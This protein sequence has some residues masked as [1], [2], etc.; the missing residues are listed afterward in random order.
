MAAL[1][2]AVGQDRELERR[3]YSH[4]AIC[5]ECTQLIGSLRAADRDAAGLLAALDVP[6][7]GRS[8]AS[9]IRAAQRE[10][11]RP[12]FGGRRAAA[13]GGFLVVAAAAAAALP[14][15]PIHRFL[16]ARVGSGSRFDAHVKS[17]PKQ[18]VVEALSPAVS[19][20]TTPNSSLEVAFSGSGV[21][22]SLYVRVIDGGE[23]S[24]SSAS[25]GATYR[26]GPNRIAVVQSAP[27][28][29]HLDVPRSLRE[30][31][32][33]VGSAIVFDRRPS[34]GAASDSFTIQLARPNASR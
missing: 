13:I 16:V 25:S 9:V 8:V 29:F 1:I 18:A 32:V 22:G 10:K 21:G 20:E 14:S 7:S 3:A 4:L 31:R 2:Y 19:F 26:V 34:T 23:V 6:A 17:G 15:S 11:S 30:L 5:A 24:L 33:L 28:Q 27:G 12:I